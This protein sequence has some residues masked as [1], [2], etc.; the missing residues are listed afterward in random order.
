MKNEL[1]V[2][3]GEKKERGFIG[4]GMWEVQTIGCKIGNKDV[5]YNIGNIVNVL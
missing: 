2:T 1:V 4:L 5:L 3:S